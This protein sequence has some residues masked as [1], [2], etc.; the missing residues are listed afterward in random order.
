LKS[1]ADTKSALKRTKTG[2]L[3]CFNRFPVLAG[4]FNAPPPPFGSWGT[5]N[6]VSDLP[7]E[8]LDGPNSLQMRQDFACHAEPFD[9]AQDKLRE[10]SRFWLA[11]RE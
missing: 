2:D 5:K 6:W 9:Y 10:A 11:E 1:S 4:H 8:L 7:P 3:T